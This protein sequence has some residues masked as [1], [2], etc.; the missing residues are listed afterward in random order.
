MNEEATVY[1][2]DL[3]LFVTVHILEDTPSSS[4]ASYEWTSGQKTT[5]YQKRENHTMQDGQLR[6]NRCPGIINPLFQFDH[7]YISYIVTAGLNSRRFYAKYS[8]HTT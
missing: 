6:A 5:S 1:V 8:N 2:Y 4:T 3:D 7:K